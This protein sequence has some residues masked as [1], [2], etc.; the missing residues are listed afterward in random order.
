MF[1]DVVGPYGQNET[2]SRSVT[3]NGISRVGPAFAA[4]PPQ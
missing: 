4:S 3:T 2:D 1:W